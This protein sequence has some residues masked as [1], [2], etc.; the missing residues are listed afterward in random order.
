MVKPA[1]DLI[2]YTKNR[3]P[4][5][6]RKL[7]ENSELWKIVA[8]LHG[9]LIL[10]LHSESVGED[11]Q[12][13]YDLLRDLVFFDLTSSSVPRSQ[14]PALHSDDLITD[15]TLERRNPRLAS[16][17]ESR[18][19][20]RI[21][22]QICT[23][24]KTIR[25]ML[26]FLDHILQ[27]TATATGKQKTLF[28][29]VNDPF[30]LPFAETNRDTADSKSRCRFQSEDEIWFDFR[31]HEFDYV[32]EWYVK[33]LY[34]EVED[35]DR[36]RARREEALVWGALPIWEWRH[37]DQDEWAPVAGSM[38]LMALLRD[39]DHNIEKITLRTRISSVVDF[40]LRN[41]WEVKVMRKLRIKY[42]SKFSSD[43]AGIGVYS[44]VDLLDVDV[45]ILPNMYEHFR[46][47][48][49]YTE[50]TAPRSRNAQ[51]YAARRRSWS[52]I[53]KLMTM[54]HC[55]EIKPHPLSGKHML[56]TIL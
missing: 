5:L 14:M 25:E 21:R 38:T 11:S 41:C 43:L 44:P 36:S 39:R 19:A 10:R 34:L 49:T 7:C 42:N 33:P 28:S 4:L 40:L 31:W 2:F 12:Q 1:I 48:D 37:F 35:P 29:G 16:L 24:V 3:T 32:W 52:S 56:V 9:I 18:I 22:R 46:N 47:A 27:T 13:R 15:P 8:P 55:Y 26:P 6:M 45:D 54:Q 23:G 50:G 20:L 30:R 53:D 51:Q 17:R